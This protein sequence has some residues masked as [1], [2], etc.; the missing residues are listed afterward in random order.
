MRKLLL[1]PAALAVAAGTG[2]AATPPSPRPGIQ[3][4]VAKAAPR[5]VVV[6]AG[7]EPVVVTPPE[8]AT[9]EVARRATTAAGGRDVPLVRG[10]MAGSVD[11][12]EPPAP[13]PAPRPAP[14]PRPGPAAMAAPPPHDHAAAPPVTGGL[15]AVLACIRRHESGGNYQATNGIYRGAYQFDARTWQ[16]VGGSGDPAAASPAEQDRRAALLYQQRG[17]QPWPLAR[18]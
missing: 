10:L 3:G 2:P 7:G 18:C 12:P 4:R 14:A 1:V 9:F 16:S 13:P 8:L 15:D 5:A 11:L 6:L 17:G